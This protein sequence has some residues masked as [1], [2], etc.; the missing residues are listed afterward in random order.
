[1]PR[2]PAGERA[3][4]PAER[5]AHQRAKRRERQE[6]L[7]ALLLAL[8]QHGHAEARTLAREALALAKRG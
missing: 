5:Q 6:R 1:M 8:T 7:V 3:L 4:T 2:Q